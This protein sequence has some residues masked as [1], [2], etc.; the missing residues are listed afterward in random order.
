MLCHLQ[1][2]GLTGS[3]EVNTGHCS[4]SSQISGAKACG[5]VTLSLGNAL[6]SSLWKL[7]ASVADMLQKF[8]SC[9]EMNNGWMNIPILQAEILGQLQPAAWLHLLEP[10]VKTAV[11]FPSEA[12]ARLW[13]EGLPYAVWL[14]LLTEKGM[15]KQRDAL[16]LHNV[17]SL[18]SWAE[19]PG[20]RADVSENWSQSCPG[21][22]GVGSWTKLSAVSLPF[23]ET[24]QVVPSR[25]LH[26]F[27]LLLLF[28]FLIPDLC[29]LLGW[30][31]SLSPMLSRNVWLQELVPSRRVHGFIF[32]WSFC[33]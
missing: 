4:P 5:T 26:P 9:W 10:L 23:F 30:I 6:G 20:T 2:Q 13:G 32:C 25:Q 21:A 14:T 33:C 28:F 11:Y 1:R 8:I 17:F 22:R 19:G 27:F 18:Q 7:F 16:T 15:G 29:K 12:A 31:I 24:W 3:L